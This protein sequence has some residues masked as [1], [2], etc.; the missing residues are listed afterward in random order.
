MSDESAVA[1]RA[2]SMPTQRK[3][4][5]CGG[6]LWSLVAVFFLLLLIALFLPAVS[7]SRGAARR[8]MCGCNLH[9]I[10]VA[11]HSYCA[12]YGC[13]PPAYTVDKKGRR[14]HSWRA[15]LL[16]FLDQ[17]LYTKYDFTRHWN[18]PGN[19]AV[20]GM[21]KASGPYCCPSEQPQNP[22]N[23][24]YVMLVGVSAFSPGSTGRKPEEITDGLGNTVAVVETSPSGILWTSPYDLNVAEMSFKINDPDRVGPRSCHAGG[25]NVLFVDGH[26]EYLSAG[27]GSQDPEAYLKAITTIN[28]G[29]DMSKFSPD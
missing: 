24:S 29:E 20:A 25:I 14:M 2:D 3:F 5:G 10:A 16:E 18:T 8:A 4:L 6:C 1:E 11:M 13:F 28:G 12:K 27:G 7:C 26:V 19:L 22:T 17:G 15:L 23:T 21:M 9:N